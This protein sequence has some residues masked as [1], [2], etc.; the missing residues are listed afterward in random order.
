LP[1]ADSAA[2][3]P[4]V[5]DADPVKLAADYTPEWREL[6]GY[7]GSTACRKCHQDQFNSYSATS[8]S[9]AL[10]DVDPDNEPFD[11]EFDHVP[12]GRRFRVRREKGQLL[13]EESL[14]LE[15]GSE[16][17]LTRVPV[18]YRVGSGHFARTYLYD[19]GG[20]FL[21]ESPITWYESTRRWSMTP[22]FDKPFHRSFSR[23]ILEN[24]LGC[25]TGQT[26]MSTISHIRLQIVEHAIGCERCHGP[27]DSHIQLHEETQ[28]GTS[29]P[30]DSIVNPGRLPRNLADAVCRQ[31]HLQGDI[32]I[33]GRDVRAADYRPGQPLERFSTVYRLRQKTSGMTVVGHVEQVGASACYLRSDRLTCTTCHNPHAR[34]SKEQRVEHFRETCLSCHPEPGCGM[35]L[36]TRNA[37]AQNDCVACHMPKSATEVPHLAFTHHR[38][39]VHPLKSTSEG[40]GGDDPL[41]PLSDLRSLPDTDR[42]RSLRLA[43]LQMFL[44]SS[45][46]FRNSAAGKKLAGQITD[47]LR[48]LPVEGVDTETEFARFQFWYSIDDLRQAEQSARRALG[49][50]DLRSEEE[51]AILEQWARVELDR[52]HFRDARRELGRLILIRSNSLDWLD[53]GLCEAELGN[54]SSAILALETARRLD[55]ASRTA[56]DSV[57]RL[58]HSLGQFNDENRVRGAAAKLQRG[59]PAVESNADANRR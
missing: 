19:A 18:R 3:A 22:G 32:H 21:F 37:E 24:C 55:P 1:I 50:P 41:I 26:Q 17:L 35:P 36:S 29:I 28:T 33:G 34:I 4:I 5:S 31:C 43:N 38:I 13:H 47:W 40:S 59:R 23:A 54:T 49:R 30:D 16:F 15:D 58:Y 45:L 6:S 56:Y 57:A 51:A 8:H 7:V 52:R 48:K 10:A 42:E 20:G 25:H 46:D 44:A 9:R 14:L 11:A 27:G 39:G 2:S 53:L 12:S